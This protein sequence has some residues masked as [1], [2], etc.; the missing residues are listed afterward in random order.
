M[1]RFTIAL[2]LVFS[3][4]VS[5]L[6]A[7]EFDQK[8]WEQHARNVI[9]LEKYSVKLRQDIRDFAESHRSVETITGDDHEW[10]N[11]VVD[12]YARLRHHLE[13]VRMRWED[14]APDRG[15]RPDD[16]NERILG[17]ALYA[18]ASA[19]LLEN[20]ATMVS[21]FNNTVWEWRL[22]R[23]VIGKGDIK[24]ARMFEDMHDTFVSWRGQSRIHK[25]MKVLE[26]Y[27]KELNMLIIQ[28]DGPLEDVL[29]IIASS[30]E[31]SEPNHLGLV[32]MIKYRLS[33]R[34]WR[35]HSFFSKK[36]LS[37]L[38]KF[39]RF[40]EGD[41]YK[42][43][44]EKP[45]NEMTK[46]E[47][48]WAQVHD[49]ML[50]LLQP[51]DILLEKKKGSVADMLIPGYWG[52][53][54]LW[55]GSDDYLDSVGTYHSGKNPFSHVQANEHRRY[56][57]KDRVIIEAVFTGV[58]V[59]TLEKFLHCDCVAVLRLK[60]KMLPKGKTREEVVED[61]VKRA[62]YHAG[63]EYDFWFNVNSSNTI[64]CSELVWQAY[65]KN[66][67]WPT[68]DLVN[69]NTISPDNV[70]CLAGPTDAFPFEVVYFCDEGDVGKGPEAW[71][72]FWKILKKKGTR[73]HGD[74]PETQHLADAIDS[75]KP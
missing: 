36:F 2:S 41:P 74:K 12:H 23:A 10:M 51:G 25:R 68:V 56:I 20:A 7:Y 60:D 8:E 9:R 29:R 33:R 52:H 5:P 19:T 62:L 61:I 65:P 66:I 44:A 73:V 16:L 71:R 22:N 32:D 45:L 34:F 48:M 14:A 1:L 46:E 18:G 39:F 69:R 3:L 17:C 59:N 47:L 75:L 55:L 38:H 49:E 63:Q 40:V 21:S 13:K 11:K 54:A 57:Q 72:K 64:V 37:V 30:S 35:L 53:T 24:I 67:T 50:P 26:D 70:A 42:D 4:F 6:F 58:V 27:I 28:T 15:V 43:K 31:V